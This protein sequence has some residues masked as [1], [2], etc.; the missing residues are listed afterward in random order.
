MS[1]TP[2]DLMSTTY[3]SP[4]DKFKPLTNRNTTRRPRSSLS[5]SPNI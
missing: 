2:A 5:L 1:A 3:E 4:S